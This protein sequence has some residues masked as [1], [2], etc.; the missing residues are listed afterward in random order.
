MNRLPTTIIL[1]VTIASF[2]SAT[3]PGYGSEKPELEKKVEAFLK[4]SDYDRAFRLVDDFLQ[5]H[6][7]VTIG[8]AMLER[9]ITEGCTFL[10]TE[11]RKRAQKWIDNFIHRYPEKPTGR[12]MMAR[13]LAVDGKIEDAFTE[14][15]RFYKLSETISR[16]LLMEIV[17]DAI[18]HSDKKVQ[19][20]AVETAEMLDDKIAVPTLIN[21]FNEMRRSSTRWDG[22]QIINVTSALGALGDTR[23]TPVLIKG[24]ELYKSDD[25]KA[26]HVW[27]PAA[28]ALGKLGDKS[29][30]PYLIEALNNG[31]VEDPRAIVIALG[32]LKDKRAR[33]ALHKVLITSSEGYGR[34][35]AALALA[36]VG[37]QFY[38]EQGVTALID[39][40]NDAS[41]AGQ[42]RAAAAALAE[43][44][45]ERSVSAVLHALKNNI[46]VSQ[47]SDAQIRLA[48]KSDRR[49]VPYLIDILNKGYNNTVRLRT[50]KVLGDLGDKRAI[51]ALKNALSGYG[52][53]SSDN[54]FYQTHLRVSGLVKVRAAEALAKLGDERGVDYLMDAFNSGDD[55]VRGNAAVALAELGDE[56]IAPILVEILGGDAGIELKFWVAEALVKLSR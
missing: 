6:P 49:A 37:D 13:V 21:V 29:A 16:D 4:V 27:G 12:A 5:Q 30:V 18:S 42:Q 36:R 11:D 26:V 48:E 8:Y 43:L 3:S 20:A 28:R 23:A 19:A 33:R 10:K 17:R 53:M 51:P 7:D 39:V 50:A 47:G 31:N 14:Y 41:E 55:M 56:S 1:L 9:V 32:E 25:E 15:S 44:G 24:F 40:L 35:R 34:V 45:D 22:L 2:A 46:A 52:Y 54:P 38:K